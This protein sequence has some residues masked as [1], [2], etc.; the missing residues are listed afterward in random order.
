MAGILRKQKAD[1]SLIEWRSVSGARQ[2]CI[3]RWGRLGQPGIDR[4]LT[5][6]SSAL[7]QVS[8]A[9]GALHPLTRLGKGDAS[10]RWPD[11]LP[12]GKAVLFGSGTAGALF[13]NAQVGVQSVATGERKYLIQGGV[14]PRYAPTGHL[15]YAQS[16]ILMAVPFDPQRQT[17]TGT[18]AP[19]AEGVMQSPTN[20][21]AQYS[22]SATGALVYVP[23]GV[24]A[25]QL[26]L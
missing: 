17:V 20:G 8:D 4:L 3:R 23:G 25:A 16:G 15:V 22:F 11:F 6:N 2:R 1:E 19:V 18:G 9:G 24:Q 26:G 13:V 12:G 7:Q 5:L 10:H 21:H 14:Y